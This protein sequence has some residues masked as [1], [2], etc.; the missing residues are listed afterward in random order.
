MPSSTAESASNLSTLP[1]ADPLLLFDQWLAEATSTEPN[2]PNA[3]A[4]ATSTPDGIPSVRMVLA[5]QIQDP[6]AGYQRFAIF[7]N[8]ESRKGEE[9]LQNPH[10]ALCFHWKSLRRQIR[11]EGPLTPL[12]AAASDAYFHS[13][14]RGSQI[15]AAA[16]NQ[17][18]PLANRQLLFDRAQAFTQAHP[19][20]IPRPDHWRGF[21]LTAQRI[22]FWIN[23]Q[24]RLHD[25]LLF[26]RTGESWHQTRLYP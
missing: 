4:L 14:S 26:T 2:D 7:T 20:E 16:S 10:A 17:S 6:Q 11:V 12:S 25:R 8:M 24:D 22:E 23:G 21:Y 5:K 3:T 9:I 1:G 13:R 18:H 15:A 19:G